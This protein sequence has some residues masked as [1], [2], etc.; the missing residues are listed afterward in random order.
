MHYPVNHRATHFF[1]E[2]WFNILHRL[3]GL[4]T[5]MHS[6]LKLNILSH[7]YYFS[8][9]QIMHL[10]ERS[11]FFYW[12]RH[13]LKP[14]NL[15]QI[16]LM[17][18]AAEVRFYLPPPRH[19]RPWGDPRN[20]EHLKSLKRIRIWIIFLDGISDKFYWVRQFLRP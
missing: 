6:F 12:Y 13:T 3:I 8:D 17:R 10:R 18:E 11:V 7:G 16:M 1:S 2:K 20:G 14:T 9:V 19:G 4:I 5:I 15:K